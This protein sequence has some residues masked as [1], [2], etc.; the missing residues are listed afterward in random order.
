MA[1]GRGV[2]IVSVAFGMGCTAPEAARRAAELG[3]DHIDLGLDRLDGTEP[4]LAIPVGDRIGSTPRTGCTVRPPR[5][6]TW[7]EGVALLRS[8]PNIRLERGHRPLLG[9]VE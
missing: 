9:K 5:K 2:G 8:A 3:F 6:C 1:A 7:D 4:E